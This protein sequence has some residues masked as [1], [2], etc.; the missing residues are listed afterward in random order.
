M[1]SAAPRVG[2]ESLR[3]RKRVST[4]QQI[5]AAGLRLFIER[6]YDATTVEDIAD[7][8]GLSPATVF[9]YFG[10]KEALLFANHEQ[11]EQDLREAVGR[12]R[13]LSDPR[14]VMVA[15]V[16]DFAAAMRPEEEEYT[17]RIRVIRSSPALMGAALRTRAS[18]QAVAA[19]ALA[20]DSSREPTLAEAVAAGAAL[21]TLHVAVQQWDAGGGRRELTDCVREALSALWPDVDDGGRQPPRP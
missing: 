21:A 19:R 5:L 12:H 16:L 9:R 8:A 15:A 10:T 17:E 14:A 6:G 20:A 3:A 2:R 11:E 4:R 1:P 7:A 18:W 13:S